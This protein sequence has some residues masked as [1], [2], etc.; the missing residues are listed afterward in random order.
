M[1]ALPILVS[2]LSHPSVKELVSPTLLQGHD[3]V[4]PRSALC[5]SSLVVVVRG[6]SGIRRETI[7]TSH[8]RRRDTPFGTMAYRFLDYS[9]AVLLPKWWTHWG[10]VNR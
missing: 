8:E 9:L 7:A 3:L 6:Y 5:M 10:Q 4:A 1:A 2:L